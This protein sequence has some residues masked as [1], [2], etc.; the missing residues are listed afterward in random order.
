ME[1]T[2]FA[3]YLGYSILFNIMDRAIR[4]IPLT[5]ECSD[6]NSIDAINMTKF[7]YKNKKSLTS[8]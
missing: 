7:I 3:L 6:S 1:I 5:A 4:T 2:H 8:K